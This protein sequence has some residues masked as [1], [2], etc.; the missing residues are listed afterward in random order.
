MTP[1]QRWDARLHLLQAI[2]GHKPPM[3]RPTEWLLQCTF[4]ILRR[5]MLTRA[6]ILPI[7]QLSV[8]ASLI[9]ILPIPDL[10]F[11]SVLCRVPATAHR[12]PRGPQ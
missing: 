7:R 4:T 9:F 5:K 12:H 10:L 11:P 1:L 3:I 6:I 2:R 8:L